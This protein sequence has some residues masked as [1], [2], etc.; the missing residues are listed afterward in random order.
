MNELTTSVASFHRFRIS[1]W[2]FRLSILVLLIFVEKSLLILKTRTGIRHIFL[3]VFLVRTVVAEVSILGWHGRGRLPIIEASC[4]VTSRSC[5][6][7]NVL[8]QRAR[9]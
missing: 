1:T 7:E 5:L 2:S 4:A 3:S 8:R 6:F 9:T